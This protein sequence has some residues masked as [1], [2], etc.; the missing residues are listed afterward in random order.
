M[1]PLL[2]KPRRLTITVSDHVHQLLI[3]CS[4]QQGRS[5]SNLAAYLLETALDS[6][7]AI[8]SDPAGSVGGHAR[9]DGARTLQPLPIFGHQFSRGLQANPIAKAKQPV[10]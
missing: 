8:T 7:P 2:R 4:D 1:N 3:A 9:I 10:P 6:C 5:L